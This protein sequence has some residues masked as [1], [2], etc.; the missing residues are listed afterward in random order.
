MKGLRRLSDT[1]ATLLAFRCGRICQ[2]MLD[3]EAV[4]AAYS[5]VLV[6][7]PEFTKD[8][9][10]IYVTALLYGDC[11]TCGSNQAFEALQVRCNRCGKGRPGL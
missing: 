11:S 10:G 1:H 4:A 9:L 3:D 5:K 7:V 6:E 8:T 2:K